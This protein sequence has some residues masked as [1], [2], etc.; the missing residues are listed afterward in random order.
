MK[1]VQGRTGAQ[2]LQWLTSEQASLV[3]EEMKKWI[4]RIEQEGA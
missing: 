1:F 2:A 3:I 4:A